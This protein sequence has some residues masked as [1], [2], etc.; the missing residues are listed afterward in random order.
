MI[1]TVAQLAYVIVL[2]A[3]IAFEYVQVRPN[4][5]VDLLPRYPVSFPHVGDK[6][7]QVPLLIYQVLSL[8]L[9]MCIDERL[10][11]FAGEQFSLAFGEKLQ[12]IGT[13]V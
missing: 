5:P 1:P 9:A 8:H 3:P 6:L 11:L 2:L 4:F 10:P 7:L 12:T 13:S